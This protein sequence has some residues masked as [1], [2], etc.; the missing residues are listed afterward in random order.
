ME[1]TSQCQISP[2]LNLAKVLRFIKTA[3]QFNCYILI[4]TNKTTVN[5]KSLLGMCMLAASL[6]NRRVT[7]RTSGTDAEMAL[8]H[9]KKLLSD[10]SEEITS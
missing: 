7:L 1:L 3:D 8:D 2:G 10:D 6:T 9:L 5:A 4:E